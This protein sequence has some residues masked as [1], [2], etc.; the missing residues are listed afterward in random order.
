MNKAAAARGE[1]F[2]VS[3]PCGFADL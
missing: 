2:S 1:W 3:G